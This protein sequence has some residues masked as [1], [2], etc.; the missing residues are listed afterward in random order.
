MI[1]PNTTNT[2]IIKTSI[3]VG[4]GM[5]FH[6]EQ[7]GK[8]IQDKNAIRTHSYRHDKIEPNF[9]ILYHPNRFT[10]CQEM[11][12][13]LIHRFEG[14]FCLNKNLKDAEAFNDAYRAIQPGRPLDIK[15]V[16][17]IAKH[18]KAFLDWLHK[19][20]ASYF[21][22]IAAPLSKQSVDD[23]IS[24]LPVWRY[25]K[26]LCERVETKDKT[27]RLSFN[28]AQERIRAVKTF[29]I[30]SHKR[31][32]VDSLPFSLEYKQLRIKSKSRPGLSSLFQLP[33]STTRSGGLWKWVSNLRIPR[34]LKQKEDSPDKGLQ[35]YSPKELK[36]LFQTNTA[37]KEPYKIY[38][39]CALLGG[40]R[41]FEISAIDQKDI[42]DP[43]KKENEKRIPILNIVRKGHKPVRLTIARVLMKLL[44]THTLTLENMKRRTKHETKYEMNNRE[45]PLPLF[46]NSSGERISQDTPGNTISIVRKEHRR[47]GLKV[48]LRTF[49][50]L[51][52]TFATY[53][54]K[55]LLEKGESESSIRYTLITLMSHESFKTT[56]HYIDFAKN[57]TVDE[58]GTMSEWV[59]DIYGDVEYLL[60]RKANDAA[61]S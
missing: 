48:L 33:N 44:Y 25:H 46:I 8:P 41:S 6:L 61:A 49:H 1:L 47:Q 31:G 45:Y 53:V 37:Q 11:N 24:R 55:Y 54:A 4:K 7:S 3:N 59:K 2:K 20:G 27:K 30:W 52:A 38:L 56:K 43:D 15:S 17:S 22:V 29:Y 14:H 57:I 42:F 34:K 40:L 5:S 19:D 21:E 51:R 60:I 36:Q 58:Y 23:D 10:E 39:Q 12:L 26:Y 9:P 28:T 50:D 13:F 18:L 35:P 32:Y 16:C